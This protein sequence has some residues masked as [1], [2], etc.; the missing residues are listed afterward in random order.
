MLQI[1]CVGHGT[2]QGQVSC[3]GHE[4]VNKTDTALAC[5]ENF[6]WFSTQTLSNRTTK[7]I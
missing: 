2:I 1:L 7:D 6:V 4:V 5:S 3:V